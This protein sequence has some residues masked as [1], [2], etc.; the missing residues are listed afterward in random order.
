MM[1]HLKKIVFIS[2]VVA[3]NAWA[4]DLLPGDVVAPKPD[5]NLL[6]V[7]YQRSERGD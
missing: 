4:I 6:Q 1:H 3:T 2:W 7:S 5:I